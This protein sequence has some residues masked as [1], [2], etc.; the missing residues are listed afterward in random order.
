ME[1]AI[2]VNLVSL[3]LEFLVDLVEELDL[4]NEIAHVVHWSLQV[5]NRL[6]QPVKDECGAV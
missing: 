5:A 6:L 1:L 2:E 4:Q 3:G